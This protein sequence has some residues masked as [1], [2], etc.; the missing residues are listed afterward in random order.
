MQDDDVGDLNRLFA[1]Y[2]NNINGNSDDDDDEYD[3]ETTS[4]A[5]T[6]RNETTV[7]PRTRRRRQSKYLTNEILR[8][9]LEGIEGSGGWSIIQSYHHNWPADSKA[10]PEQ[11]GSVARK[12]WRLKN[13]S[14]FDYKKEL[15]NLNI[16]CLHSS[17]APPT[18]KSPPPEARAAGRIVV[19]PNMDSLKMQSLSLHDGAEIVDS[20]GKKVQNVFDCTYL[21]D[22][23]RFK[24]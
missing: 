1:A 3:D 15:D 7:E 4:N 6:T 21:K 2:D 18:R 5:D 19:K 22:R 16:R 14:I 9:L 17:P 13:G 12:L 20:K 8:S 23:F 11:R 24:L 10:T